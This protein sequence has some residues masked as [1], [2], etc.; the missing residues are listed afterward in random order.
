[1]IIIGIIIVVLLGVLVFSLP[2]LIKNKQK[3]YFLYNVKSLHFWLVLLLSLYTAF[4]LVGS[5]FFLQEEI[6]WR[7]KFYEF[8]LYLLLSVV[9]FFNYILLIDW[10][11]K[12][13]TKQFVKRNDL[14]LFYWQSFCL[15]FGIGLIYWIVFSQGILSKDSVE[16]LNMAQN[17]DFNTH[18]TILYPS[19]IK[20]LWSV[21]SIFS[22]DY[23][24]NLGLVI[25]VQVITFSLI[26]S[27]WCALFYQY[28]FS[29]KVLLIVFG[30][31]QAIPVNALFMIILWKDIY[32]V[33]AMLLA[34]YLFVQ[35]YSNPKHAKNTIFLIVLG[36][37]LS[38]VGMVRFNGI[39]IVL[40][41]VLLLFIYAFQHKNWKTFFIPLLSV[42]SCF[43][44]VNV[45]LFNV[46]SFKEV[47]LEHKSRLVLMP[48]NTA[49]LYGEEE[50][51]HP[52]IL[53]LTKSVDRDI[54]MDA[55][56]SYVSSILNRDPNKQ[57]TKDLINVADTITKD[58]K[59]LLRYYFYTWIDSPFIHLRT[60]VNF[61]DI[62]WDAHSGTTTLVMNPIGNA[63]Y[64][65]TPLWLTTII[66]LFYGVYCVLYKKRINLVIL[67]PWIMNLVVLFFVSMA[68][69]WRYFAAAN[70]ISLFAVFLL[71][72][73][74]QDSKN[75]KDIK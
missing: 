17:N 14:K 31:F 28:G 21:M 69:D 48:V 8:V 64:F 58:N 54:W 49:Y 40:G 47:S 72:I 11:Q 13:S 27:L 15:F 36:M 25:L 6:L 68:V 75:I 60:R 16:V 34:T 56:Y 45:F 22:I 53:K 24:I 3:L 33:Q 42:L 1:M 35:F 7:F 29:K 73:S 5:V 41:G 20:L 57:S 70:W 38:F 4:S 26:Y 52:E 59:T 66:L 39:G 62:V 50:S 23:N 71:P 12:K 55:A 37:I 10:L 2:Y 18:H 32:Y 46:L 65:L 67:F 30:L 61:I 9:I 51:L 74:F 44:I 43:F 63:S 19:F